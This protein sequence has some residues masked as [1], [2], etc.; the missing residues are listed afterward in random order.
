MQ[1]SKTVLRLM[2]KQGMD[3]KL[4]TKVT[5]ECVCGVCVCVHVRACVRVHVCVW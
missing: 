1:V 5:G 3:F 4:G 2:K